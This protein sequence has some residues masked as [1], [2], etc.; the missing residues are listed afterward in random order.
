MDA[1]WE[2]D[3]TARAA[4][5]MVRRV[6]AYFAPV[7]RATGAVTVFDPA[8][9]GGFDA[10]APPAPWVDLGWVYGFKRTSG[11]KVEA[12]RSGAPAMVQMQV[13]TEIEA[14]LGMEF[15]TWGKVQMAL[16]AGSQQM[17]LLHA[18]DGGAAAASGGAAVAA[19][20]LQA[21]STASVL[22]VGDAASGFAVGDLV[23][24]DVDYG[25]ET[26]FVGSGMSGA[27][28]RTALSDVDYVRRITLNVA[29]VASI[30]SGGLT[31][32]TPLLA[33]V[34]ADGMKVSA[35][36][37]F[38]DR[39]G[40][41]FFQEW[42][43]LFVMD[44]Q[45]GERVALHYPRLQATG[46]AG[47]AAVTASGLETVRLAAGFRALPVRDAVDGEQVV[48]FRSYLPHGARV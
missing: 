14:T 2:A 39:E 19:T 36:V 9:H 16:T 42:T 26:G 45:Q 34:P 25:G 30:A 20:V 27:Y 12:V 5:P 48:C 46:G 8:Q 21:G 28:V 10:E 3:A 41:S 7:A 44:G 18:V 17:N 6:R 23:A 33:G 29:R 38:C 24:V 4:S 15:A 37:G 13:R 40:S 22:Q 47:E 31:L 43:G 11:T 32:E 1:G 35:V